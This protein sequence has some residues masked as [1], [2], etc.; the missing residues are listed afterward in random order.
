MQWEDTVVIVFATN[1]YLDS[2][3]QICHVSGEKQQNK[4]D[5]A[6]SGREH[7]RYVIASSMVTATQSP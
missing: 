7:I 6:Y 3:V 5:Q 4:P 2:R 1:G